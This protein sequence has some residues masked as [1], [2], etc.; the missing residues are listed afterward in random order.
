[1]IVI[2][3]ILHWRIFF[4]C[5]DQ[6]LLSTR[7]RKCLF[8]LIVYGDGNQTR[9][10]IFVQDIAKANVQAVVRKGGVYNLSSGTPISLKMLIAE[11]ERVGGHL[12]IKYEIARMGDIRESSLSN[13]KAKKL[14]GW[15]PVTGF[16]SG[17]RETIEYY[18]DKAGG[19]KW[20]SS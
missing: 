12:P 17:I 3:A 2:F 14:L 15:E 1:M 18:E 10:F 19:R 6:K 4:V 7:Q 11:L 5:I 13:E 16:S 20:G 9:D 8:P